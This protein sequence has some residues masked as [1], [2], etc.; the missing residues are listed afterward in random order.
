MLWLLMDD[1]RRPAQAQK[2]EAFGP[3]HS[4]AA[5][6]SAA[7]RPRVGKLADYGGVSRQSRFGLVVKKEANGKQSLVYE[8]T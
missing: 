5:H 7:R 1:G 2:A 6:A 8:P 3:A 4:M